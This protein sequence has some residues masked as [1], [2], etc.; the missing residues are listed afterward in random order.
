M[1]KNVKI[2]KE[3]VNLAKSLIALDEEGDGGGF[4]VLHDIDSFN[5]KT[6]Y[7]PGKYKNFTGTIDTT[8]TRN[9][10]TKGEVS[11]ATFDIEEDGGIIWW[12]GTWKSGVFGAQSDDKSI[13]NNGVWKDGTFKNGS[14]RNGTWENGIFGEDGFHYSIWGGGTWKN[15]TFNGGTWYEGTWE[16]GVWNSGTWIDGLWENGTWKNGE[17]EKGEYHPEGDSPDKW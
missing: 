6:V 5:M 15:G 12:N 7:Q 9:G 10:A 2:A 16:D 11:N 8:A 17:D 14:W 13:W 1:N 4:Q 3:L